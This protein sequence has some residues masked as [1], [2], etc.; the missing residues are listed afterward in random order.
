MM[1]TETRIGLGKGASTAGA[2]VFLTL[3]G[4]AFLA[5][6]V[7]MA[8]EQYRLIQSWPEVE[9]T[10][11]RSE[12]VSY[13]G[14]SGTMY[15][16]EYELRYTVNGKEYIT[17]FS[18]NV[19]SSSRSG[20]QQEAD[21]YA[22]GTRHRIRFNPADPNDVRLNV[23]FR[24]GFF[25]LPLIFGGVGLLVTVVGVWLLLRSWRGPAGLRCPSC[26]GAIAEEHTYCPHCATRLAP[27]E[28]P[29]QRAEAREA[30]E[31]TAAQRAKRGNLIG[32]AV[33]GAIG[34]AL[35]A[36]A[37]WL[38]RRQH[39]II[40][41][42]PEADA[43]VTR[44]E[45]VRYRD[46]RAQLTFQPKIQFRY[47]VAGKEHVA[48]APAPSSNYAWARRKVDTYAPGT[49][50]SIR[51]NPTNPE[52]IRFD[53]G[54]TLEFFLLPMLLGLIGLIFSPL[55]LALLYSAISTKELACNS[56]GLRTT[57]RFK[58]CPNCSSPF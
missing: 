16:A 1:Q 47:V 19:S 27:P 4:L 8:R 33:F 44:S 51:Y 26:A 30:R 23:G 40:T 41:S 55:G 5:P 39:S 46:S 38:A 36:S 28:A 22:P 45:L 29:A 58:F 48:D 57:Q 18:S 25:L 9:A 37:L 50:H 31:F 56:C 2:G 52:D 3:L 20:R 13:R 17:P 49:R 34:L 54:F 7:W 21:R 6:A 11:V 24:F 53:A 15:R 14:K 42:W 10:G 12:V 32:G 43:M 35:L